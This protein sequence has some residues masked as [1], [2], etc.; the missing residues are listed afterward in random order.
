MRQGQPKRK[1]IGM[2]AAFL[3]P[4]LL[5]LSG[6]SHEPKLSAVETA[7]GV[8]DELRAAVRKEISDPDKAAEAAGLVDQLEQV[9]IEASN[10]RKSHAGR[11]RTLNASYDATEEDFKAVFADFNE[12]QRGRQDRILA[13]D[14]RSRALT[15]DREWKALSRDVAHAFEAS[16]RAELGM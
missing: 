12:K 13:I 9:M 14:E 8:F 10:A 6:C 5:L 16:A 3:I 11:I 15:T 7:K 4:V 1:P 2:G